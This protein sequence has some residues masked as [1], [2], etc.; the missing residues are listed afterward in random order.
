MY[1]IEWIDYKYNYELKDYL[2]QLHEIGF[3]V[4]QIIDISP[5]GDDEKMHRAT[6]LTRKIK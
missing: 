6:I 4:V 1:E 3:E 5:S 2:N